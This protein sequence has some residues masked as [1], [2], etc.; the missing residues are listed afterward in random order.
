MASL[1][2]FINTLRIGIDQGNAVTGTCRHRSVC[3]ARGR[4]ERV[5]NKILTWIS[6]LGFADSESVKTSMFPKNWYLAISDGISLQ[7]FYRR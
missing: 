5:L 7:I 3:K 1:E 6:R 2:W 4:Q